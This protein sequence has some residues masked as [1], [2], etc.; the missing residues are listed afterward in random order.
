MIYS[1][2]HHLNLDVEVYAPYGTPK[3]ELTPDFLSGP[4]Q[5][6]LEGKGRKHEK[7]NPEW[8]VLAEVL[9][10]LGK[11]PY[12][13]PV[14]RT[15]FQKI[16]YVLTEMGVQTGFQFAKGSYGP[17]ADEVKLALQDFANRNWL[18]EERLGQMI[19][20]RVGPQYERDRGKFEEVLKRYERKI[21][22]TVDLFSRIKN[23]EQ[24]EEVLT[25]V[26]ASRELKKTQPLKEI[27]E[28]Q[29]FDYILKWKKTWRT[30]EKKQ[31]VANAIRNLVMLGWI[32]LRFS[33]TLPEAV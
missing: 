12:A 26:F 30:D 29:L 4:S 1:K 13:N 14:G 2:L 6:S 28:Q 20:L 16:C 9:L 31:A 23:T 32:R 18:Q 11:Q 5:L 3:S 24:A 7:L 17:F 15:I 33:E 19:A 21:A 10:E 22:K 27:A 25:V 8:V